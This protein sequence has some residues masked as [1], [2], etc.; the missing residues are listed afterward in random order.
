M[1]T[2]TSPAP[3]THPFARTER[4]LTALKWMTGTM[5]TLQLLTLGGLLGVF[6]RLLQ[7]AR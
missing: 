3:I 2:T 1:T 5:I 4:D 7:G 6:L